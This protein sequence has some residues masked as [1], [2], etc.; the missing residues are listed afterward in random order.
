MGWSV[1]GLLFPLRNIR[2]DLNED[3]FSG[4]FQYFH[5]ISVFLGFFL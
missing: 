5:D 2:V 3:C 1:F 4:L